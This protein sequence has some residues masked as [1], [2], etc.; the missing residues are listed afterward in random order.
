MEASAAKDSMAV[1]GV[2]REPVSLDIPCLAEKIRG[3]CSRSDSHEGAV[4]RIPKF[5]RASCNR[6][7]L[8][9][10]RADAPLPINSLTTH[11]LHGRYGTKKSS[12]NG[13][14]GVIPVS[15][16]LKLLIALNKP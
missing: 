16:K 8:I 15:R 5:F 11:N 7:L 14:V 1:G 9:R 4:A 6:F 3:N 12:S 13:G 10:N 2:E